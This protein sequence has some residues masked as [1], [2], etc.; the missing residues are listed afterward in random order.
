M[1]VVYTITP[2]S[3]GNCLG[4]P[5]TVTVTVDPM[6]DVDLSAVAT[7]LCYKAATD[8]IDLSGDYISGSTNIGT[9]TTN[10]DGTFNDASN[11]HPAVTAYTT[12][13]SDRSKATVTL[14]LTAPSG[15]TC[16]ADSDNITIT[17]RDVTCTN[18]SFFSGD[19]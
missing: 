14:T 17:I 2:I 7:D 4:D 16:P 15:N 12:G 9:W 13:T 19:N 3:A 10:G 18:N 6:V 5:F 1:D 11:M 8:L